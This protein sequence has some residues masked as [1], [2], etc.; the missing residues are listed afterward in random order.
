MEVQFYSLKPNI[1]GVDLMREQLMERIAQ[2]DEQYVRILF[3]VSNALDN[4]T[5]QATAD[6]V[7]GYDIKTNKPLLASEADDVFEAIVDDVKK[8]NYIE[9]DELIV[10][11]SARW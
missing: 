4:T 6:E 9:I 1:M 5:E 7:I 8:G 10:Q 11:K 2:G 3:A